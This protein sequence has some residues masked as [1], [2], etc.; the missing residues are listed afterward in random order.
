MRNVEEA[1]C[2]GNVH[3]LQ[4]ND[5]QRHL[6][7][8]LSV[9]AAGRCGQWLSL[10]EMRTSCTSRAAEVERNA[11]ACNA[12]GA[13]PSEHFAEGAA[14]DLLEPLESTTQ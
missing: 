4:V 9:P 3:V 10:S 7:A 8:L 13:A 11:K 6:A 1:R 5:L 14:T 12:A 2:P